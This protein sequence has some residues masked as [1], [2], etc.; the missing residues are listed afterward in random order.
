LRSPHHLEPGPRRR[1]DLRFESKG[2]STLSPFQELGIGT[3]SLAALARLGITTPVPVQSD[4][5]PSLL[6]G[7]DVVIEAP[8][9][10]GKT[11]AFLLPMVERL[12]RPE[13]GPRALVV[14]PVRELAIQV[15]AVYRG[16][17]APGRIATLYGGVGY[18][19]QM[20]ALRQRPDVVAGT[21]GRLLDMIE[22]GLLTLGRVRYLVLDEA[23]EMLD[24]GFAPAVERLLGLTQ[25]PQMVLASATMPDWVAAMIRKHLVDPVRVRVA[26]QESEPKLEHALV[27][28]ERQAKLAT[29]SQV[30]RQNRGVIVF[31]RTKHGVR[32]LAESLRRLQHDAVELQGN[33]SQ[34][35]RDRAMTLFRSGRSEVLVATNV[36]ARGLDISHVDLVVNY[37]L[38][39][40]PE[41]LTHRVGRT[42]RM[43]NE[44]RALTFL[45][46][47]DAVSWRKLRGRGA[48]DLPE[49]D[50]EHLLGAG[51]WRYA[52][53]AAA[54]PTRP[55]APAAAA[56]VRP[57]RPFRPRYRGRRPRRAA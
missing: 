16:L 53:A 36:A 11:L 13:P 30:L 4:A 50:V 35:A 37:E 47:D 5:I 6:A 43:G 44:G 23:D 54:V 8:T 3:R 29:L 34:P 17:G 19:A 48:P 25:R 40:T 46:P 12:A 10:S 7:R 49:L 18:N 24:S 27:R 22:R 15:D 51:E 42:A 41:S 32:K 56:P 1:S 45:T 39:E 52:P 9:G 21:P 26:D 57:V 33:M 20:A 38:P 31:G 28:V 55:A 14:T 2:G